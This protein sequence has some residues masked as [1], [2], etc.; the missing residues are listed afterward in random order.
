MSWPFF[1]CLMTWIQAVEGRK[2]G[3]RE[4][5]NKPLFVLPR[6]VLTPSV[7]MARSYPDNNNS[8]AKFIVW[9]IQVNVLTFTHLFDSCPNS[10]LLPVH[11]D[12]LRRGWK[13]PIYSWVLRRDSE[14]LSQTSIFSAAERDVAEEKPQCGKNLWWS[15]KGKGK[16]KG[17]KWW[18]YP[19]Q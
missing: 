11:W 16:K 19:G 14:V 12:L 9:T 3:R 2:E 5:F 1:N 6:T 7:L 13:K 15:S 8:K 10:F 4:S 18:I 17:T